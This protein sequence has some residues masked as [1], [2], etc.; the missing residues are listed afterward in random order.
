MKHKAGFVNII[1]NPNVGKSTLMNALLGERLSVIS[2]KAQTTRHR[3]FGILNDPEYQIV[4]SDT[5]GIIQPAYA[6]QQ[7]MMNAVK[8]AFEDADVFLYLVEPG[9]K[10][11]KDEGL[12]KGLQE[13][14][15]PVLLLINKI[16]LIDQNRLEEV[17]EYWQ[18][19]LPNAEIIPISAK[20][21]FNLDYLLNRLLELIPE[22]PPYFDKNAITDRTERF[23]V[24]EIIREKILRQY[25]KEVPYSVQVE[26]ES[27]KEEEAIIRIRATIHVARESQKGIIIGHRGSRLKG[28]GIDA[29]RECEA[30]F[31][32]KIYLELFVKVTKNWRDDENKLKHFGY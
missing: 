2:P 22:S 3:I 5:P 30:F 28:V 20:T 1:G 12:F 32:K 19:Q 6:L 17:S 4:F 21:K 11:L 23:V 14:H 8:G 9:E 26:V 25:K 18:G 16:D 15:I 29:R 7:N 13:T 27:F 24:S 31:K 10:A